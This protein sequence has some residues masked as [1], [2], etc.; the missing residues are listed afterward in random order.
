MKGDFSRWAFDAGDNLTGVLSQQ[1]RVFTDPDITAITQIA[2]H[3]RQT[4]GRDAIG[5]AV[6]AV[7]AATPAGWQVT[8]AQSDGVTVQVTLEPGRAWVDGAHI[9]L[10]GTGPVTLNVSYLA[11]PIQSPPASAA[12]I[13][14]WNRPWADPTPPRGAASSSPC[15]C[16]A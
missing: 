9:E 5:G 16:C 1:G 8:A 2:S 13:G 10:P 3:W 12:T 7:P 14:C 6:A 15:A 11:P 4:L